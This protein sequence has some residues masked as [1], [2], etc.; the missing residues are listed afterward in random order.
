VVQGNFI[1][2][3]VTGT[4]ALGNNTGVNIFDASNNLIGG[5]SA[6]RAQHPL[7]QRRWGRKSTGPWARKRPATR[8][9]ATSSARM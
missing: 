7:G 1:G 4:A 6:G 8:C 5:A 2:T 9:K 3:D